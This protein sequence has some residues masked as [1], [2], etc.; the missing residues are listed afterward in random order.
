MEEDRQEER[1]ATNGPVRAAAAG[2][3]TDWREGGGERKLTIHVD[4][5]DDVSVGPTTDDG[6]QNH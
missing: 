5:V 1:G 3:T 2:A 6:E 4:G